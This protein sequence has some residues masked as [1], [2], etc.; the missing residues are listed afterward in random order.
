MHLQA[1]GNYL[2]IARFAPSRL[3]LELDE[4]RVVEVVTEDA[5]Y[6]VPQRVSQPPAERLPRR[7]P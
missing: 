7:L 4:I 3:E 2:P 5:G 1:P 6:I